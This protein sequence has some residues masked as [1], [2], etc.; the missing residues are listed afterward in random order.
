MR[1][2][3]RTA[4]RTRRLYTNGVFHSQYNPANPVTGH[5]WDLL[6]IPAFF[7]APDSVQRVL[8]LGVGGGAV[9]GLL[10]RF[11]SPAA[12]VGFELSPLHVFVARR[13]SV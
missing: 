6:M 11:V 13:F 2:Q 1:Y 7:H 4:G 10:R 12:V 9:I 8:V 3:V 5:V